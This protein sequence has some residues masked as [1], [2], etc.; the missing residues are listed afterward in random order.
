MYG[1][2]VEVRVLQELKLAAGAARLSLLRDDSLHRTANEL[3]AAIFGR[4]YRKAQTKQ[5]SRS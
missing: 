4:G 2:Q 3:A 5:V 1:V